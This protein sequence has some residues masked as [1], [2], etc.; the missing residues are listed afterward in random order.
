MFIAKIK[1]FFLLEIL[2]EN[3]IFIL[4][5]TSYSRS[6]FNVVFLVIHELITDLS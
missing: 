5:R 3:I 6:N 4:F 1:Y 2:F